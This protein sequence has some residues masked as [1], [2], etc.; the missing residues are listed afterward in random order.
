MRAIGSYIYQDK[1]SKAKGQLT[2]KPISYETRSKSRLRDPAL[3]SMHL[4][5]ADQTHRH[6][7]D[8]QH[9][10]LLVSR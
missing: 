8:R 5:P 10:L 4:P 3:L 6:G 2:I 9:P 7:K 1:L